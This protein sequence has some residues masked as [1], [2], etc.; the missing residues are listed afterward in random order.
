VVLAFV[1]AK[2]L[3]AHTT[4]QISM[5]LSLGVGVA[6][7]ALSVVVS[8]LQPRKSVNLQVPAGLA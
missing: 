4:W 2:M 3:L 5:L 8:L 1:A 7:L 6:I